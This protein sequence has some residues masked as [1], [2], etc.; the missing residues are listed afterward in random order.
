VT[1][2]LLQAEMASLWKLDIPR[3]TARGDE[4]ALRLGPGNPI[5]GCF[6]DSAWNAV[7]AKIRGMNEQDLR[8]QLSLIVGSFDVR[9]ANLGI[10]PSIADA[11]EECAEL[12]PSGR[13]ELLN[14][15]MELANEIE[16]KA[17]RHDN[18]DIG[19]MVLHYSPAAERYTLQ[20]MENDLYNGRAGVGL[21]YAALEKILPGFSYRGLADA[22]LTP[23]R[24]WIKLAPDEELAEFGFGGYTGLSSIAY[25]LT[26]AGE[27]LGDGELI[28][29]A[30]TAALRI[31]PD[32]IE[33]D[34]SLDAMNGAA[35]AIPGLLACYAATGEPKVLATA[36]A[37]GRHLLQRREPDQ[38]GFRTW[39]TLDR[40]HLT[41]FSHGAAGIAYA[42]LQLYKVTADAE[43][44][45]A[46]VDG[47]C[48]EGHAF[49]PE[50]NNWPDYRR[51]ATKLSHD[52][53]FCMSWCHGAPG[54][55]LGRIAALDMMDT[56]EVRRDIQAALTST[57]S[58]NLLPR[59]H[60]C[61]GNAGLMDTLCA[62][63]QRFPQDQWSRKALQLAARTIA[64]SHKRGNFNI[65]FHNGFFNPSLFQGTA[66]V[67]Y[68]LLRLADPAKIPS[69]L[70]LN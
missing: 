52:P 4:N 9:S 56:R 25:A 32:Q 7:Q 30:S 20:P 55:G 6:A 36:I 22:A 50:Q 64:R 54:I 47:I 14:V 18:G 17:F 46:A 35:G 44:H 53:M 69:V 63:G 40:C 15:A 57:S 28:A 42:L 13:E 65:A 8:W 38:F 68:Q 48:F 43:F 60:L 62:A 33:T 29:D 70:L 16:T 67:G 66:G 10:D 61:C 26:R 45:D 34:R 31:R 5:A 19:W 41:G 59:D 1:W 12:E 58:A 49:V 11:S 37:C 27:F 21:F 51:A 2:P 3:F 23:V 24:R 39:P